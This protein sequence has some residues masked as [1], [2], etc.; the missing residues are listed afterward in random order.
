MPANVFR[1]LADQM[2]KFAIRD[3]YTEFEQVHYDVRK[4]E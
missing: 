1:V 3:L 2:V 4:D